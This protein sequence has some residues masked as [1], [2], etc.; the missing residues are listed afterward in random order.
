MALLLFNVRLNSRCSSSNELPATWWNDWA[1]KICPSAV[2]VSHL[3]SVHPLP[4]S[5]PLFPSLSAAHSADKVLHFLHYFFSACGKKKWQL[6]SVLQ[7][8]CHPHIWWFQSQLD[9]NSLTAAVVVAVVST[10]A[11]KQKADLCQSEAGGMLCGW[12]LVS[13]PLIIDT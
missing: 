7:S 11:V 10:S 12:P 6:K 1:L 5:H 4:L 3:V 13:A 2:P 8:Q 9:S